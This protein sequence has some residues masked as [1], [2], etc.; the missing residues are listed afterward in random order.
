MKN[1]I[2]S[3]KA[4]LVL[5][6][7]ILLS[8]FTT[9]P[10]CSHKKWEVTDI[11]WTYSL[12]Q[13]ADIGIIDDPVLFFQSENAFIGDRYKKI[14][15]G[16]IIFVNNYGARKFFEQV[17]P[18]IKTSF[19]LLISGGDTS[20]PSES[21]SPEL[22]EKILKDDKL[23][24]IF[25]MNCDYRG[26][27][28]KIS[29]IPIGLG[30][31]MAAYKNNLGGRWGK[32]E[33]PKAQERA[34]NEIIEKALPTDQR[35]CRAFVDFQLNNTS[36]IGVSKRYTKTGECRNDIYLK[37]VDS[38]V[39]DSASPLDR[40]VLWE[41][42]SQYAFSI[43]PHGNGLDCHRTWEDLALGCIVI[44]KT[45]VLDPLYEGLPVVIVKDW[46]EVNETNFKKWLKEYGDV[47]KNPKYREKLTTKYW[48]IKMISKA[49]LVKTIY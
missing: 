43:S 37:I 2:K 18:K 36:R 4:I 25:S 44:V 16:D 41:T 49:N 31:H 47:S 14:N 39:I 34:L 38:G 35:K 32:Y 12:I 6:L 22:T 26:P 46:D 27:S 48:M 8:S 45:S 33:S 15:N 7:I 29:G 42:K 3:S 9:T 17:Y 11:L 40:E 28:T 21:I 5:N 19:V 30:F 20:F 23:L 10:L 13:Q 24:H 1:I